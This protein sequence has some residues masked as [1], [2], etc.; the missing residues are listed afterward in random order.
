[1]ECKLGHKRTILVVI[2][3]R[4][5]RELGPGLAEKIGDSV[6]VEGA[7]LVISKPGYGV[8]HLVYEDVIEHGWLL[9]DRWRNRGIQVSGTVGVRRLSGTMHGGFSVR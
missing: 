1:M 3:E 4:I 8:E 6:W 9:W 2:G 7:R 5:R